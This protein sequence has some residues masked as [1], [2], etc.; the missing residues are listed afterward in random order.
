MASVAE[1]IARPTAD[2]RDLVAQALEPIVVD[3]DR[4]GHYPESFMRRFGEGGLYNRHTAQ[5]GYD[6]AGAIDAMSEVSRVC[7]STGFCV[8]C[9][10]ALTWYLDNAEVPETREKWLDRVASGQTLGGTGLS[11]GMKNV[12][13]IEELK[14]HVRPTEGGY[15][16]SGTLPWVSNLAESH[17]FAAVFNNASTGRRVMALVDCAAPGFALKQCAEFVALEGS[18]TYACHFDDVFIPNDQVI[19]HDAAGFLPRI[20]AGFVLLQMGMPLGVIEGCIEIMESM[21]K[22]HA[23]VNGYLDEQPETLREELTDLRA[24]V[25]ALADE[26]HG[27][28]SDELFRDVLQVRERG[29]A[30]SLRASQ[31]AMLHAGARGYMADAP[32]QRKLRESYFVAIVTPA[33]KHIRKELARLEAA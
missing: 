6:F 1:A 17:V 29:S 31:A 8:W 25:N 3:I 18:G 19:S 13:A 11:N 2:T 7:M 12:A 16:A 32:A 5:N 4:A 20:R 14:I 26:V 23:H 30:L 21:A 15:I 9:H 24:A 33:I 10:D 28:A 27:N 22:T